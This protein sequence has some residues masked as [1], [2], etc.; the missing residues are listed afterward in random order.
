MQGEFVCFITVN[1]N[2]QLFAEVYNF[3]EG[4]EGKEIQAIH[5]PVELG[6]R[7]GYDVFSI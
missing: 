4:D 5:D 7:E 6:S 1:E 2:N 3:V